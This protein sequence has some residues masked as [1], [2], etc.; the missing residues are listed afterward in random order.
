M[1]IPDIIQYLKN[2]LD[3]TDITLNKGA[4]D[5]LIKQFEDVF[6][7]TMP[8][9]IRSF[10]KFTNGFTSAEDNF[11][12]IP[13]EKIIDGK[14]MRSI[15]KLYIAEYMVYCDMWELQINRNTVEYSISYDITLTNSFAEFIQRFLAGGVFEKGGLYEWHDEIKAKH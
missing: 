6:E 7:V 3:Q 13:L 10:Y 4:S 11:S 12:I 5:D 15:T 9:D 14:T 1:S 8:D 2:H